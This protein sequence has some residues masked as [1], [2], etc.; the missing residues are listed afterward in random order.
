MK[1][2]VAAL[3][4]ALSLLASQALAQANVVYYQNAGGGQTPVSPPNPLPAADANNASYTKSTTLTVGGAAIAATRGVAADCS[5]AGV[6]TLT[7]SGGGSVSWSVAVGH[8]NQP[9]SITGASASTAAC[10]LYGLN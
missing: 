5:G 7:M 2:K 8:Q 4:L 10:T 6:V 9:Y 3:G 1:T